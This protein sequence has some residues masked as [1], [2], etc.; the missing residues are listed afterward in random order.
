M[1][2]VAELTADLATA[3]DVSVTSFLDSKQATLS[4]VVGTYKCAFRV[5]S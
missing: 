5:M 4:G 1:G 2:V 3:M